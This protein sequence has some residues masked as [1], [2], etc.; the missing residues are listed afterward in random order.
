MPQFNI[1]PAFAQKSVYLCS[2]ISS[3]YYSYGWSLPAKRPTLRTD[4]ALEN[5]TVD[6]EAR[7]RALLDETYYAMGYDRLETVRTYAVESVF[8]WSTFWSAM[9][10]NALPGN[11][12]NRIKFR[13]STNTF[14][15][16]IHFL[17]GP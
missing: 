15:G 3:F 6:D 8:D 7:G 12:G 1:A 13:F 2:V 10:M 16:Q 14:D 5:R 11:K 9:P 4:Y 17:E